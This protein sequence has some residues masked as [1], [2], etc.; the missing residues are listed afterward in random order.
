MVCPDFPEQALVEGECQQLEK[1]E[2]GPDLLQLMQSTR[3]NIASWQSRQ[4]VFD[5]TGMALED[6]VALQIMLELVQEQ[7][8]GQGD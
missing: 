4:T 3:Q 5:S 2:I 7:E 6:H 1:S 8:L